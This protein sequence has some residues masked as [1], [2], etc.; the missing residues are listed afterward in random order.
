MHR[1]S[2]GQPNPTQSSPNPQFLVKPLVPVLRL[3]FPDSTTVTLLQVK[4][5][6]THGG[7]YQERELLPLVPHLSNVILRSRSPHVRCSRRSRRCTPVGR[8]LHPSRLNRLRRRGR[9]SSRSWSRRPR[10]GWC[11]PVRRGKHREIRRD[12]WGWSS[13]TDNLPFGTVRLYFRSVMNERHPALHT[14]HTSTKT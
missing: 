4:K 5:A 7:D 14:L 9:R 3:P 13:R 10:A 1:H 2:S 8:H 12:I 6:H 11:C